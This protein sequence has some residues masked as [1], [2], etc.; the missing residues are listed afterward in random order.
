M[1]TGDLV[2]L[3]LVPGA[4]NDTGAVQWYQLDLPLGAS[5]VG[6]THHG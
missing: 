2:E 3:F 5:I 1:A 4:D 6:D